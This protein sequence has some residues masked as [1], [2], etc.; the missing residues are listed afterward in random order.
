MKP[1]KRCSQCSHAM[2]S[3]VPDQAFCIKNPPTVLMTLTGQTISVFPM[4]MEWGKCDQ[5]REGTPQSESKRPPA[6]NPARK[7]KAVRRT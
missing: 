3:I 4:M 1:V 5:H 7:K 2:N 6:K